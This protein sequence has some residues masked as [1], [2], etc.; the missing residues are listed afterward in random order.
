MQ[1][2]PTSEQ[3]QGLPL[4]LCKA[5]VLLA[6]YSTSLTLRNH[7]FFSSIFVIDSALLFMVQYSSSSVRPL[8]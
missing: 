1:L 2:L 4:S 8:T 6:H 3:D 5:L 7:L